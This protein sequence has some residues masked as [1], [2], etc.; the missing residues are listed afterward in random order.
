MN[1]KTIT[2]LIIFFI[3]SIYSVSGTIY[4]EHDFS[5]PNSCNQIDTYKTLAG[6]PFNA[7]CSTFDNATHLNLTNAWGLLNFDFL[8]DESFSVNTTYTIIFKINDANTYTNFKII[9]FLAD[10]NKIATCGAYGSPCQLTNFRILDLAYQY[11]NLAILYY[12]NQYYYGWFQ[13]MSTFGSGVNFFN[14]PH[15]DNH[16][17]LTTGGAVILNSGYGGWSQEDIEKANP[18]YWSN[19]TT[20]CHNNY[21][22][23]QIFFNGADLGQK[24]ISY[25]ISGDGINFIPFGSFKNGYRG[26]EY[27]DSVNIITDFGQANNNNNNSLNEIFGS[28]FMAEKDIVSFDIKYIMYETGDDIGKY[29]VQSTNGTNYTTPSAQCTG[30]YCLF[31]DDFLNNESLNSYIGTQKD[32]SNVVNGS[33][34]INT[35]VYDPYSP[36]RTPLYADFTGTDDFDVIDYYITFDLNYNRIPPELNYTLSQSNSETFATSLVCADD[37]IPAFINFAFFGSDLYTNNYDL[38]S[39]SH[40]LYRNS[41]IP[42]ATYDYYNGDRAVIRMRYDKNAELVYVTAIDSSSPVNSPMIPFPK[43]SDYYYSFYTPCTTFKGVEF[44][45]RD[46][47]YPNTTYYIGIDQIQIQA[48]ISNISFPNGNDIPPDNNPP[49][50]YTNQTQQNES[51]IIGDIGESLRNTAFSFGFKTTSSKLLLW[52]IIIIIVIVLV[53]AM[54][55]SVAVKTYLALS[56]FI[57]TF[58]LG[59]YL[60]FIP[61]ALLVFMIFISAIVGALLIRNMMSGGN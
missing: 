11:V 3:F 25:Y 5:Q 46:T 61:T 50:I 43:T 17:I 53:V 14:N 48:F 18:F 10:S 52:S 24:Y 35:Y 27:N 51:I 26:F 59:W 21:C 56:S 57:L 49:F 23:L 58:I 20:L 47:G 29:G 22:T 54:D 4:Y 36:S 55:V 28:L 7:T 37:S 45:R 2:I 8:N 19:Y 40:Y 38:T 39:V 30:I 60:G 34:F 41:Y 12:P 6:Y 1:K 42:L 16:T 32:V 13:D 9:P 33:V 15:P 44:M 31:K